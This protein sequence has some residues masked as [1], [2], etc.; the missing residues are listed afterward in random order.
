MRIF[1][2]VFL[3]SATA[4]FGAQKPPETFNFD[5]GLLIFSVQ[6]IYTTRHFAMYYDTATVD[7]ALAAELAEG[8]KPSLEIDY[9]KLKS[10]F[11]WEAIG[12]EGTGQRTRENPNGT[13][14][15]I[16]L[17]K[18]ALYGGS[19]H[20]DTGDTILNIA[21]DQ[22][23]HDTAA[24]LTQTYSDELSQLFLQRNPVMAEGDLGPSFDGGLSLAMSHDLHPIVPGSASWAYYWLNQTGDPNGAR[25]DYVNVNPS[26]YLPDG[27]YD[28]WA[29]SCAYS[30]WYWLRY[31][32]NAS[33]YSVFQALHSARTLADVYHAL[34][35]SPGDAFAPFLNDVNQAWPASKPYPTDIQP[36]NLFHVYSR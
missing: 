22:E 18:A 6:P 26:V 20:I 16:I 13:L 23:P 36:D 27:T 31:K 12:T 35:G 17:Y 3:L 19:G 5:S 10:Y 29:I 2:L 28:Y 24:Q 9:A 11:G 34:T 4:A 1:A 33:W 8:M 32:L 25:Y 14:L 21:I 15:N 30:Y 7:P